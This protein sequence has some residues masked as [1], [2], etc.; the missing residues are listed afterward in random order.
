MSP[1]ASRIRDYKEGN[2]VGGT[3]EK[4]SGQLG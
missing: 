3:N 1:K 2:N 4:T